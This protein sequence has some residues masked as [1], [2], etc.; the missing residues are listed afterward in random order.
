MPSI[1]IVAES[2][3]LGP[4]LPQQHFAAIGHKPWPGGGTVPVLLLDIGDCRIMDF[5]IVAE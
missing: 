5:A 1:S 2:S 3:S 4:S